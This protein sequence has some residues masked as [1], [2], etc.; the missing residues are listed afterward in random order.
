MAILTGSLFPDPAKQQPYRYGRREGGRFAVVP[1]ESV[2][3]SQIDILAA[4][5]DLQGLNYEVILTHGKARIEIEYNYNT[6][7][8][9]YA[10][11]TTESEDI[12][13]IVPGKALK[14]LLDSRNPLIQN[15]LSVS[16]GAAQLSAI[17]NM[18]ANNTLFSQPYIANGIITEM[19]FYTDNTG[20]AVNFS[21]YAIQLIQALLDG[22][23]QVEINTPVLTHNKTVTAEYINPAQFTNCGL[24][25]SN[26]TL[27]TTESIPTSVLF[28]M[29]AY[30][31]PPPVQIGT[32]PLYQV[33]QYGWLKNAP[34]VRQTSQKKWNIT[35]TYD[36]G[37]WL[38]VLYGGTRL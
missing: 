9:S 22:V 30:T 36:F 11:P 18:K 23:E 38:I 15:V 26:L 33:Y 24:I 35:Q 27:L 25:F 14:D 8:G 13:E 34:S 6:V 17:R 2:S 31:D 28:D 1:Y 29:P 32:L 19:P 10:G 3:Q 37:L 21:L 4:N 5:A 7:A 20:T 12:W 16:G